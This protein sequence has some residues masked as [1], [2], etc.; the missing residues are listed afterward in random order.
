[1]PISRSKKEELVALYVDQLKSCNGIVI[2]RNDGMSMPQFDA[3]RAKM[4]EIDSDLMV[5]KNTLLALA[6]KEVGMP[7]AEE[8]LKGPVV[9]AFAKQDLGATAKALLAFH[10]DVELFNVS[11]ALADGELYNEAGVK[12][13]SELP[14]LDEL[15]GQLVGLIIAPASGLVNVVNSG[16]TQVL[17]VVAAYAD[18]EESEA[19]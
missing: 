4:R 10:K 13:L 1:M 6:L 12:A 14:S 5:I 8:L 17:N 15:R 3:L 18:K 9:V 7:V 19:A 16:V 2:S 11:G